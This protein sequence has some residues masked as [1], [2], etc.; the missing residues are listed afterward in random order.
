MTRPRRTWSPWPLLGAA[1]AVT[2]VLAVLVAVGWSPLVDLDRSAVRHARGLVDD[3]DWLR[4]LARGVT[5][6]GDPAVVTALTLIAAAWLWVRRRR[7]AAIVLLVVRAMAVVASS[8]LKL[9]VDRPRPEDVPALTHVTTAS[10]P[11]GHAL[12]SA[13]LWV[14]LAL[15]LRGR[16]GPA[17]LAALAVVAPVLVGASR[18]L[19]GVHFPSDVVAGLLLGW[20]VAE[21]G[22]GCLDRGGQSPSMAADR[23]R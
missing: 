17:V 10:F 20:V 4:T 13:A 18:V 22:V 19:L 1:V 8:G 23:C 11:S 14:T 7:A 15:L 12:G 9:L 6:A 2:A 3:H 16:F 21:V 5:H